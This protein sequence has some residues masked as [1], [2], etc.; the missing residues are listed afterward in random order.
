MM[1]ASHRWAVVSLLFSVVGLSSLLWGAHL[2]DSKTIEQST[3]FIVPFLCAM[4]SA[5]A[6]LFCAISD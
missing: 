6:T 5:L 2:A 1:R 3:V 4:C